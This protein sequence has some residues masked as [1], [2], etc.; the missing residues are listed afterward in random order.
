MLQKI[1][2][3]MSKNYSIGKNILATVII[4]HRQSDGYVRDTEYLEITRQG[5]IN[6][7]WEG[8]YENPTFQKNFFIGYFLTFSADRKG[9]YSTKPYVAGV[10]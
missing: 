3:T 7:F 4:E 10:R 9:Y 8:F 1:A 5:F 6:Y 2:H